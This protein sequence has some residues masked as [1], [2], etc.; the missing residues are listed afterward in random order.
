MKAVSMV[1]EVGLLEEGSRKPTKGSIGAMK[2]EAADNT[3]LSKKN[4][5]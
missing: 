4:L 2:M 3:Q 1:W 5:L